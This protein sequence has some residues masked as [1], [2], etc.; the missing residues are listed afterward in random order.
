[1]PLNSPVGAGVTYPQIQTETPRRPLDQR[2][3]DED[4]VVAS[5]VHVEP[6]DPVGEESCRALSS[7]NSASNFLYIGRVHVAIQ[8]DE[9][10][11]HQ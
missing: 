6:A 2:G 3:A 5:H 7:F 1:M 10:G 11:E 9:V 4:R 8:I